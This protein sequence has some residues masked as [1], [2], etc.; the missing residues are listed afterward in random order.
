[1]YFLKVFLWNTSNKW[2]YLLISTE[3]KKKKK[4]KKNEENIKRKNK[5][6]WT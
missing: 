4:N 2:I 3:K 6:I 5:W 1:M